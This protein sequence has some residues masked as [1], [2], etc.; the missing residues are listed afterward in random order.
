MRHPSREDGSAFVPCWDQTVLDDILWEHHER[1]VGSDNC[2]HYRRRV[3]QV[4][5]DRHRCHYVRVK[6]LHYADD[7]LAAHHGPRE[8]ARYDAQNQL[9]VDY[10]HTIA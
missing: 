1:T 4:P 10:T 2:V 7:C 9:M 6:V 5:A 8:L 3:L